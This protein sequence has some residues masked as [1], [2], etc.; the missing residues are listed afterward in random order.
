MQKAI[1]LL[2][3]LIAITNHNANGFVLNS[4]DMANSTFEKFASRGEQSDR[5]GSEI[6]ADALREYMTQ[7]Q[8]KILLDQSEVRVQQRFPDEGIHTG[9]SCSKT[10]RTMG[11]VAKAW[12]I[13]GTAQLSPAGVTYDDT[14]KMSFAANDI[15]HQVQVDMSIRVEFGA[16]IFGKCKRVGRKTCGGI[17]GTSRGKNHVI[18]MMQTSNT[19]TE[20]IQNREHLVF[21]VNVHVTNT[22]E[23]K[24]YAPVTA[25]DQQC[26]YWFGKLKATEYA[27][28]YFKRNKFRELRGTKLIKEL[29]TKLGAKMGS[30]VT[31]PISTSGEPRMC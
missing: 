11:T 16:K 30:V 24:T 8:I 4:I 21:N 18:A 3:S 29:E 2:L 19:L 20:C 31:I 1:S 15:D 7:N 22:A 9:H 25:N 26:N 6:V 13:P 27:N 10:A 12:M 17:K 23:D 28:R 5:A 14:N